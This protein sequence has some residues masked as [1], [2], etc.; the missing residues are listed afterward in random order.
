MWFNTDMYLVRVIPLS[1]LPTN[2]PSTL[3]Y[4][5]PSTL[6]VGSLVRAMMGRRSITAIVVESLDVRTAKLSVKK[7]G[8]ELKRLDAVL[9][10]VPLLTDKQLAL[11]RWISHQY[12]CSLATALKTVA[13]PFIGRKKSL[14]NHSTATTAQKRT[15]ATGTVIV[16]QPETSVAEI[17]RI[18]SQTDGR[19]LILVP[20][21]TL[22]VTLAGRV[23]VPVTVVH[24]GMPAAAYRRAYA[25]VLD[26]SV[27]AVIG[28][29]TALFLPWRDISHVVVE[30]PLNET[31]KSDMTPRYNAGDTARQL[32]SLHGAQL[33]WLTPAISTVQHHMIRTGALNLVHK[34]P[35]W[36]SVTVTTAQ[37]ETEAGQRSLFSRASQEAIIRAY[38]R[39]APLLVFSSRRAYAT[40]ARCSR[41]LASVQ[42]A[43]CAIPMR[44]HRTSEDMLVCYHCASF[45]SVP[46]QCDSC[47]AGTLRP[48]GTPGSQKLAEAV[49][50]VLDRYG[51]RKQA[52]P[53]LDSDLVRSQSDTARILEQLDAAE[54]PILVASAMIFGERYTRSFDTVIVPHLD[55]LTSNPDY[56]TQDRLIMQLE[57]LADFGP[58]TMVLQTFQDDGISAHIPSR[59]WSDFF[60]EELLHRKL[61]RWPPYTRIVKLS[62]SH[63]DKSASTRAAAVGAERIRRSI[64]YLKA[65]GT[66]LLGP[67]PALVEKSGG[68]WT[69][70]LIIKSS[71]SPAK[72]RELLQYIPEGWVVDVDPR[73]I[74]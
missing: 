65:G 37:E 18:L 5:W 26:G 12:S 8:F 46:R 31:Y 15:S 22:A 4:F 70:T 43:T 48:S 64:E 9:V 11:T 34:K 36:P 32:A 13:P 57:K 25:G 51:L 27:R 63:R 2:A 16:S 14:L 21:R 35:H 10:D 20:E 49:N 41:C 30:D 59:S 44:W 40:V 55:A 17:Q 52:I 33:T 67:A 68:R 53:I 29:R 23:A 74:S 39:R 3:D 60:N 54:H 50:V 73:S 42:C 47:H 58:D 66:H 6:P 24:G 56:R 19:V 69:Q 72:L 61:L 1:K 38:D 28:T 7:A 62:F 45:V 71:L